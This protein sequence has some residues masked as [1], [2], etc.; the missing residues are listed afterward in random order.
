M[1]RFAPVT[2]WGM[3]QQARASRLQRIVGQQSGRI[4]VLIA[5]RDD[6]YALVVDLQADLAE[7]HAD[8]AA[9]M[10]RCPSDAAGIYDQG[11]A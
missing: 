1:R 8:R 5:E 9:L 11:E 6:A 2:R 4:R 7:L 10:E 3:R